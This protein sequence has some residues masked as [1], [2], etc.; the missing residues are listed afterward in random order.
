MPR[1]LRSAV[2]GQCAPGS[3][4]AGRSG[5]GTKKGRVST[6]SR[7]SARATRPGSRRPLRA[8]RG[9]AAIHGARRT[10]AT[11]GCADSAGSSA[12][13]LVAGDHRVPP[14]DD[15]VGPVELGAEQ[16]GGQVGHPVVVAQHREVV[17]PPR[18][19]AL[20]AQ[21]AH[22]VGQ[23]RVGGGDAAALTCGDHL[24]AEER[25]GGGVGQRTGRAPVQEGA[26]GL[27]GVGDQEQAVPVADRAQGGIVGRVAVQVDGDDRP[28]TGADR[29]QRPLRV[30]A[31]ALRQTSTRRRVRRSTRPRWRW[32]RRSA[33]GR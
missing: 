10:P 26:E 8:R 5:I 3:R 12:A 14:G 27:R 9:K 4:C 21:Q 28:G 20:V 25:E 18:V 30:D 33:R 7:S 15:L 23:R 17:P 11:T 16:C 19:H 32:R 22:P 6:P 1:L 13:R 24:V 31:P 2:T 29:G